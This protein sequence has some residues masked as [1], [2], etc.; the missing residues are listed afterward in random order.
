MSTRQE[1][2]VWLKT[3][4]SLGWLS[5]GLGEGLGVSINYWYV[6]MHK[7][8][9]PP[10]PPSPEGWGPSSARWWLLSSC[11]Q[12]PWGPPCD[13]LPLAGLS[14]ALR[15][16]PC[17]PE[18]PARPA[19]SSLSARGWAFPQPA[20]PGSQL[21]DWPASTVPSHRGCGLQASATARSNSTQL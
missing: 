18:A 17:G 13:L 3:T 15:G 1:A 11:V 7:P 19:H 9:A 5:L 21:C 4:Q 12:V 16:A 14:P 2:I 6:L 20:C 10:N 8:L